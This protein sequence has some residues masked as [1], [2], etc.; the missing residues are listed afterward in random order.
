MANETI[1]LENL[2][3]FK[4]NC[5]S[6]YAKKLYRHTISLEIDQGDGMVKFTVLSHQ[7]TAFTKTNLR[8]LNNAVL[9]GYYR[10]YDG[11]YVY[12]LTYIS[13]NSVNALVF[14]YINGSS[15]MASHSSI[16]SYDYSVTDVVEAL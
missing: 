11:G 13:V 9:N 2:S 5:D 14:Y 16:P 4:T 10:D 8:T 7:A 1:S 6:A 12:N 15:A 3:R